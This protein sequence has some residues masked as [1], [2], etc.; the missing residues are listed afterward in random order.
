MIRKYFS[1]IDHYDMKIQRLVPITIWIALIMISVLF[2]WG[3]REDRDGARPIPD[4]SPVEVDIVRIDQLLCDSNGPFSTEKM[5]QDHPIFSDVY[6]HQ[7]IYP[8][9]TPSIDLNQ[10]VH[11]FCTAPAIR[12]LRDTARFIFPNLDQLEQ[13]LGRAFGYFQFY[14]PD[15]PI[16]QVYT[17]VSEFGIGTFTIDTRV[18]GI[19]LDFFLG[20]QY[21]YYDPAVFPNYMVRTMTPEY[22]TGTAIQALSQALLSPTTAGNMLDHMIYN[23]KTIYLASRLLPWI[24]MNR[25]CLYSPDQMGWVEDN[26]FQIWAYFLDLNNFYEND[27]RKFRKFVD[28][29]PTTPGM[30]EQAPGRVANWIG[31]RIVEEYMDRHPEIT[32]QELAA[33]SDFQKIMDQSRYKPRPHR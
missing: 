33:D 16:P 1:T 18:L 14:F 21:P 32:L 7:I 29:G 12:H 3:C 6:F 2:F 9:N 25:I 23:G 5:M 20:A 22:I 4:V 30:P 19:G 11:N 31:Y 27:P 17:Y 15:L 10:L 26:E 13:E 28:P 24:P 8:Q